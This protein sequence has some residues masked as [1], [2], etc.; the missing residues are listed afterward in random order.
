MTA[1]HAA[2]HRRRLGPPQALRRAVSGDRPYVVAFFVLLAILSMMIVGP[3]QSYTAAAERVRDLEATRADLQQRAAELQV[4]HSR[5]SDPEE[6]ELLARQR[7]GLVRPGEIPYVVSDGQPD[8][9]Q[10]RP[11]GRPLTPPADPSV[12]ERVGAAFASLFR[13]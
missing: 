7:L 2:R 1:R 4:R 13:R 11:D 6:L 9:D 10:V 8:S 12:I 3:L 5:L